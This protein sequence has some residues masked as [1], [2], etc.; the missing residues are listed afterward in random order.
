MIETF[1]FDKQKLKY[2]N[3]FRLQSGILFCHILI[4]IL[5][6]DFLHSYMKYIVTVTLLQVRLLMVMTDNQTMTDLANQES[7]RSTNSAKWNR[8]KKL[9]SPIAVKGRYKR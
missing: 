7:H 1:P 4:V 2:T 3:T 5:K 6:P 8:M 9:Q